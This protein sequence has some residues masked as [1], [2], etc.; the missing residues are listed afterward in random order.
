MT[1]TTLAAFLLALLSGCIED[2]SRIEKLRYSMAHV[3]AQKVLSDAGSSLSPY[4][5]DYELMVFW[6]Y[7]IDECTPKTLHECKLYDFLKVS[8]EPGPDHFVIAY[9]K[10]TRKTYLRSDLRSNENMDS[11]LARSSG[12]K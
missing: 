1:K 5:P 7:Y 11:G 12:K 3:H 4:H 2:L 6:R 9:D 8:P 10:A